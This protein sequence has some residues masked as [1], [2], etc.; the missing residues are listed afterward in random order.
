MTEH[1]SPNNHV[2]PLHAHH[3]SQ[4]YDGFAHQD[5][6]SSALYAH[7]RNASMSADGGNGGTEYRLSLYPG[8]FPS[9]TGTPYQDTP[10]G[11]P[12]PGGIAQTGQMYPQ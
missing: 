2:Q 4:D 3:P 1:K 10:A 7:Q 11:S 5:S 6:R 9:P 12:I 8:K